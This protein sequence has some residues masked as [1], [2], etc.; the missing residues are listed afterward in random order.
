MKLYVIRYADSSTYFKF[1]NGEIKTTNSKPK[2]FKTAKACHEFIKEN[3]TAFSKYKDV[4]VVE[5]DDKG[6]YVPKQLDKFC[7]QFE[8][9]FVDID[10]VELRLNDEVVVTDDYTLTLQYGTVCGTTSD[11]IKIMLKNDDR[12]VHF[13]YEQCK[14]KVL[15][16]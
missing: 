7:K 11:E 1:L 12:I 5:F 3:K 4:V 6:L 16:I 15:S 10:D 8:K 2:I 13:D 9:A 14:T